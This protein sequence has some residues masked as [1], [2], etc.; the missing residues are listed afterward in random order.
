MASLGRPGGSLFG[1][2]SNFKVLGRDEYERAVRA[3]PSIGALGPERT[4][5]LIAA[6]VLKEPKSDLWYSLR[7]Q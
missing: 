1:V 2:R 5:I 7:S 3:T 6:N 4:F